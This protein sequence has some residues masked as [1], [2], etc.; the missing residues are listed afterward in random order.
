MIRK[1]KYACV[2]Q[3]DDYDCGVAALAS[4]LQHYGYTYSYE[5][6]REQLGVQLQGTRVH[7]LVD[8]LHSYGFLAQAVR[9]SVSDLHNDMI[10]PIILQVSNSQG[11]WHYILLYKITRKE[12]YIIADPIAGVKKISK[13]ELETIFGGIVIVLVK[14]HDVKLASVKSQS[15]FG[16]FANLMLPYKKLILQVIFMSI[17]L[18]VFGIVSS[19][20]SKIV[21]D[22]LIPYNKGQLLVVYLVFFSFVLLLQNTL[23]AAREHVLLFFSRKID[24][25]LLL[26]YFKHVLYLS[27]SYFKNRKVGDILTRFQDAITI[28]EVFSNV[29]ISLLMDC[30]LA[31]CSSV[32]LFTMNRTLFSILFVIVL[33]NIVLIYV[34]KKPYKAINMKQMEANSQ[35]NAT[36]IE[37]LQNMDTVKAQNNEKQRLLAIEK[38][39]IKTL[40]INYKEGKLSILQSF[41]SNSINGLA[42]YIFL[43]VGAY[44][45]MQ[46]KMS[47][48]DLLVFQ[49]LSQYF[50]EPIQSLVS[51]QLRFQEVGIS[52]DRL[53]ELM[54]LDSEEMQDVAITQFT[55]DAPIVFHDVSFAYGKQD[56]L[57]KQLRFT[58][59]PGQVIGLVGESGGGKTSLVR[60]LLRYYEVEHGSITIGDYDI[61]DLCMHELRKKIAYVPQEV[62][63]FSG[64][65]LDNLKLAKPDASYEE[66]VRVCKQVGIHEWIDGLEKRYLSMIQEGSSNISG[67]QKQRIGIARALLKQPDIFI[68][69][70][71]TSNLD[72]KSEAMITDIIF[73]QLEGYTRILIAHRLSTIRSCD[74]IHVLNQGKILESGSHEE[75]YTRKGLYYRML[76][77]T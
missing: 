12:E 22:E 49:T 10:Y 50:M 68:F 20:C 30:V 23:S 1:K 4:V 74:V 29:A 54:E 48:G 77:K 31:I 33:L 27:F 18:T 14:E 70:E 44:Y 36:L 6:L 19:L 40:T 21:M 58:I 39:F 34:F 16:L 73:N 60:L 53:R 71:V 5:A 67:G 32:I 8:V 38:A 61:K 75:L 63:L 76:E 47:I 37:T 72:S 35:M 55:L 45:I 52:I 43:G 57:F 46:Q 15:M 2:L 26:G 3:R 65:L 62:Q 41:L 51:L 9:T 56:Y 7:D 66:I 42:N 59:Q 69:D 64:T 11:Q 17:F 28:K 13:E 25:P 24:I